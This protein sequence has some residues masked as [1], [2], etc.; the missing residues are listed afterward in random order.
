MR[1]LGVGQSVAHTGGDGLDFRHQALGQFH[2]FGVFDHPAGADFAGDDA[3][4]VERNVPEQLFPAR[5]NDV[6]RRFG[7]DAAALE[8]P[9][10][11]CQR[12]RGRPG[13]IVADFQRSPAGVLDSAGGFRPGDADI[14]DGAQQRIVRKSAVNDLFHAD[15]VL[16]QEN[17]GIRPDHR[18]QQRHRI[19]IGQD[20]GAEHH[21]VGMAGE[22]LRP[23]YDLRMEGEIARDAGH[24]NA[25]FPDE[26]AIVPDHRGHLYQ[27]VG[28][29][30]ARKITADAAG[31]DQQN[32]WN[33]SHDEN[34]PLSVINRGVFRY[35][36]GPASPPAPAP[37]GA[38][39]PASGPTPLRACPVPPPGRAPRRKRLP[40]RRRGRPMLRT[41]ELPECSVGARVSPPASRVS[42]ARSESRN[43]LRR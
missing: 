32:R 9:G 2:Q 36:P 33:L 24:L 4:G 5:L 27:F 17:S 15:A 7:A 34:P 14:G 18:L 31:A 20:F 23:V 21:P 22:F 19:D 35:F 38:D 41:A 40:I 3:D 30:P 1:D 28:P 26:F 12:R 10:P 42:R 13:R 11:L 16:N 43:N 25:V 37:C 39:C 8:T 6:R 29:G